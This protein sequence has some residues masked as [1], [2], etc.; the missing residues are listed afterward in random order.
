MT[1]PI[2]PRLALLHAAARPRRGRA[3]PLAVVLATALGLGLAGCGGDLLIPT[4]PDPKV[5]DV[6]A[7]AFPNLSQPRPQSRAVLTPE[8]RTRLEKDLENT[9]KTRERLLRQKLESDG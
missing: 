8:Q 6:P 3:R 4:P 2:R 7:D 9:A 5:P 1:L